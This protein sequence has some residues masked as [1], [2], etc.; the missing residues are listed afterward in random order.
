L[1]DLTRLDE[2][3]LLIEAEPLCELRYGEGRKT[4]SF[5]L[6]LETRAVGLVPNAPTM[7]SRT[8][9]HSLLR[10]ELPLP[11]RACVP[12]IEAQPF[13]L[14]AQALADGFVVD[15]IPRFRGSSGVESYFE[16]NDAQYL[17]PGEALVSTQHGIFPVLRGGRLT[18]DEDPSFLAVQDGRLPWPD[19]VRIESFLVL[20]AH[21]TAT[22]QRIVL[23]GARSDEGETVEAWLVTIEREGP[24]FSV[25]SSTFAAGAPLRG[26]LDEAGRA[27]FPVK[28]EGLDESHILWTTDGLSFQ[29]RWVPFVVTSLAAT[30][31]PLRPHVFARAG[32][33]QIAVGDVTDPSESALRTL[34][35][36]IGFQESIRSVTAM[37]IG[38]ALRIVVGGESRGL[39][40]IDIGRRPPTVDDWVVL[41]PRLDPSTVAETCAGLPDQ[42]AEVELPAEL[43]QLTIHPSTEGP[44]WL[45]IAPGLCPHIVAYREDGCT[46]HTRLDPIVPITAVRNLMSIRKA[47]DGRRALIATRGGRLFEISFLP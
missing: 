43:D 36:D 6:P 23:V 28:D 22:R 21:S 25:L 19:M 2:A 10:V 31:D 42:C 24:S 45:L 16:L 17:T 47:P 44:L 1:I 41:H 26:A 13:A 46:T 40:M 27:L 37:K 12:P 39:R 3:K 14:E 8:T 29:R 30:T 5:S 4:V 35:L 9:L 7:E 18:S 33:G 20:P 32:L 11:D 15:G 34:P 38:D